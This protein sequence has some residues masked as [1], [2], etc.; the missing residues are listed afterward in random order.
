MPDDNLWA[1]DTERELQ[2]N[3]ASSRP[4]SPRKKGSRL[5]RRLGLFFVLLII[6]AG[7]VLGLHLGGVWD[8]RP[9]AEKLGIIKS[10]TLSPADRRQQELEEWASRLSKKENE[11]NEKEHNLEVLSQDLVS[12]K[13]ALLV[14][15]TEIQALEKDSNDSKVQNEESLQALVQTFQEMSSRR[16]ASIIEQLDQKLAV[17]L[18]LKMPEDSVA[19]ILGRMD[20]GRA[21]LLTEQL[22]LQKDR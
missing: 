11:L 15:E 2:E 16:A 19:S 1:E 18:L 13:D 3:Q 14:K 8:I 12:R 21:A 6:G 17:K 10:E 9:F 4:V 7:V 22:A 5:R 20:P